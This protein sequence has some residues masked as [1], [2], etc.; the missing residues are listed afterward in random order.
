MQPLRVT[1][2][3]ADGILR[4]EQET[5]HQS[6]AVQKISSSFC[7]RDMESGTADG[8]TQGIEIAFGVTGS[9]LEQD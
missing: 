9:R 1:A 3:L 6:C 8:I 5:V 2:V 4:R 7:W